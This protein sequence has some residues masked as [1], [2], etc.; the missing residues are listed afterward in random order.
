MNEIILCVVK[1]ESAISYG[2]RGFDH[3]AGLPSEDMGV[4]AELMKRCKDRH[5][6]LSND[7]SDRRARLC[8]SLTKGVCSSSTQK[9]NATTDATVRS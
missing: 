8:S 6:Q 5:T 7:P 4:T 9:G 2:P 1:K 3:S